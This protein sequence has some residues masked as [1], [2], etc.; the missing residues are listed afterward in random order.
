MSLWVT[1]HTHFTPTSKGCQFCLT[2]LN[3]LPH[4]QRKNNINY[5]QRFA[6]RKSQR[7][8]KH[9]QLS[10]RRVCQIRMWGKKEIFLKNNYHYYSHHHWLKVHKVST[11]PSYSSRAELWWQLAQSLDGTSSVATL[12]CPPSP[13]FPTSLV[14]WL[15]CL[16][17]SGEP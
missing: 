5:K 7:F 10:N 6:K 15:N 4:Q 1:S 12:S 13:F 8:R 16:I 3:L 14:F 9:K 2:S 17:I 11:A